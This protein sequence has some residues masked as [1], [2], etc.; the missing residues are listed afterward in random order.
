MAA[1]VSEDERIRKTNWSLFLFFSVML[2][3]NII[4][5][6]VRQKYPMLNS[7]DK[8][9]PTIEAFIG[10]FL[11]VIRMSSFILAGILIVMAIFTGLSIGLKFGYDKQGKKSFQVGFRFFN[12]ILLLVTFVA[13]CVLLLFKQVDI[14]STLLI[15]SLFI[16]LI[17]I[18]LNIIGKKMKASNNNIGSYALYVL[19]LFFISTSML[20]I[21]VEKTSASIASNVSFGIAYIFTLLSIMFYAKSNVLDLWH[22]FPYMLL[23]TFY[24]VLIFPSFIA[25]LANN[26]SKHSSSTLSLENNNISSVM[27]MVDPIS[28]A[29]SMSAESLGQISSPSTHIAN[30]DAKTI[31][32]NFQSSEL[33]N[34]AIKH[35][36]PSHSLR[37]HVGGGGEGIISDELNSTL[38]SQWNSEL[39]N[40]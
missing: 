21:P 29:A 6:S 24:I 22:L 12:T 28:A 14:I 30:L 19:S 10:K 3:L 26:L 2:I 17:S 20:F 13:V 16:I 4:Y 35:I 5:S 37:T 38:L 31:Q 11:Q 36:L 34:K 23:S 15:G 39:Q 7:I 33:L 1:T 18:I 32:N 40:W 8:Y 9:T 27:D 25:S